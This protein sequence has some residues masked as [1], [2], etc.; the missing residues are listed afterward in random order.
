MTPTIEGFLSGEGRGRSSVLGRRFGNSVHG[1]HHKEEVKA[2][3]TS[4]E[5]RYGEQWTRT[6]GWQWSASM[7]RISPT[8]QTNRTRPNQR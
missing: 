1:L 5:P 7:P 3:K 6:R 4:C 8:P 2:G